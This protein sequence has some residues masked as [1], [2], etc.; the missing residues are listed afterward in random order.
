[1][2]SLCSATLLLSVLGAIAASAAGHSLSAQEATQDT[3]AARDPLE[4]NA[5]NASVELARGQ[6]SVS[7]QPGKPVRVAVRSDSGTFTLVAD[8]GVVARWADSAA[9][10][11]EPPPVSAPPAKITF[12]MWQLRAQGDSGA[13]MRFARVPTTHGADLALAVFNGAWGI[14][15]YLGPHSAA[16]LNALR[17]SG[18]PP[19][20]DSGLA[21]APHSSVLPDTGDILPLRTADTTWRPVVAQATKLSGQHPLYPLSLL[22]ARITGQV[23]LQFI[24][25]TTGRAEIQSLRLVT[26]T[27]PL[28]ALACRNALPDWKFVP[29]VVDGHKV[30]ELVQQPFTFLLERP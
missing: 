23:L 7:R 13:H 25:D 14:V 19:A 9:T 21:A 16:V 24:I 6:L 22:R 1:M 26:S 8:S 27:N 5:H 3:D 10:L 17:G 11:P 29:A 28:F 15:E 2:G 4:L 12:K 18:T 30:R 20:A